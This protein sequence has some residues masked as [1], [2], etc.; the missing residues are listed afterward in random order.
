M[1]DIMIVHNAMKMLW[2]AKMTWPNLQIDSHFSWILEIVEQVKL[3]LATAVMH[4]SFPFEGSQQWQDGDWTS[5]DHR[6]KTRV[7][8]LAKMFPHLKLIRLLFM[9]PIL[10]LA[11]KQRNTFLIKFGVFYNINKILTILFIV[12][13]EKITLFDEFFVLSGPIISSFL[14][15]S[16]EEKKQQRVVA[17]VLPLCPWLSPIFW[18]MMGPAASAAHAQQLNEDNRQALV[19]FS[20]VFIFLGP[21][22]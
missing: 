15:C 8:M 2:N 12:K 16:Y 5:P 19:L 7:Q 18:Q 11:T 1:L 4:R 17:L 9:G 21:M 10:G 3:I 20:I 22:L 13:C 14:A 6:D